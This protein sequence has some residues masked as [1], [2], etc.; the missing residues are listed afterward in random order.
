MYFQSHA[1]DPSS[2]FFFFFF[3]FLFLEYCSYAVWCLSHNKIW[4]NSLRGIR[5]EKNRRR[6][7]KSKMLNKQADLISIKSFKIL[8]SPHIF[9]HEMRELLQLHSFHAFFCSFIFSVRTWN[10]KKKLDTNL[11][12]VLGKHISFSVLAVVV[13]P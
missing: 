9:I 13:I 1:R 10:K 8:F 3:S 4:M 2:V 5:N 12:Y 6:K 11:I 7:N